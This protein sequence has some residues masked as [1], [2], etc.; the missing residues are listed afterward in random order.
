MNKMFI[1]GVLLGLFGCST[2]VP[3]TAKFPYAPEELLQPVP[4]L[5]P[6]AEDKRELSDLL[7]NVNRNY[8]SY[9]ITREKLLAWQEWYKSQKQIFDDIK[10]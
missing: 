1:I 3:I 8:G 6:L 2:A 4:K 9:Y 5:I 7:S 10:K